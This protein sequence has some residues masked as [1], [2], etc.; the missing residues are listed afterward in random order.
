MT[1]KDLIL[2]IIHNTDGRPCG[3]GMAPTE[4]AARREAQ[5]QWD[6]HHCYEGER[7]GKTST[8]ILPAPPPAKR[9]RK[10]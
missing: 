4:E 9:K 3:W 7:R 8:T 2:V 1:A 5:R 10:A 6:H